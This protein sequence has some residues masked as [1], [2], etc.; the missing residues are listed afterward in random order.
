[1]NTA[2]R[3][4]A[5]CLCMGTTPVYAAFESV[6]HDPRGIAMSGAL[7]ALPGDACS[8]SYN[9]GAIRTDRGLRIAGAHATPSGDGDLAANTAA[10]SW[11]GPPFDRHGALAASMT[12]ARGGT[13]HERSGTAGYCRAISESVHAGIS[14][15]NA[16]LTMENQAGR[17]ATGINAGIMAEFT[18]GLTAGLSSCNLNG[19]SIDGGTTK[20]PRTTLAGISWRFENGNLLT[21]NAQADPERSARLLAAGE[22]RLMPAVLFMV[23][24][25]TNPSVISAGATVQ[26]D[27]VRATAALSRN[28]ELG[29][30]TAFGIAL[31]L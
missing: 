8:I 26:L 15:T 12:D 14:I 20:L 4:L 24:S 10:A 7:A 2:P 30:T 28:I 18:T 21:A 19:S 27:I 5:L 29:T 25:G 3:V 16:S 1:M 11:S 31:D 9:P 22:F 17:S 13:S 23:G 6:P